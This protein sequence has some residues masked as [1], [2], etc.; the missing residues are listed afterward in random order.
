MPL[1]QSMTEQIL[2]QATERINILLTSKVNKYRKYII[3]KT[4][5]RCKLNKYLALK[6][7]GLVGSRD[8]IIKIE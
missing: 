4:H 5:F 1:M 6:I 7:F 3:S 8:K 2:K